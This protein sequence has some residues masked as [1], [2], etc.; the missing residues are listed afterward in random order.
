MTDV[1]IVEVIKACHTAKVKKFTMGDIVIDFGA[2][3][4]DVAP[5]IAEIPQKEVSQ[6][7]EQ[8]LKEEQSADLI[9]TDP[10]AFE[11]LHMSGSEDV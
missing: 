1:N 4:M 6:A 10:L 2:D 8:G 7:Q 11:Q 5:Y 9:L 3:T